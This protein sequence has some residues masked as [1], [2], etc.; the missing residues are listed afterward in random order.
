M[1]SGYEV[2][3]IDTGSARRI[4]IAVES[5]GTTPGYTVGATPS[6]REPGVL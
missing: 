5:M 2:I 4:N 1:S 3:V 6:F